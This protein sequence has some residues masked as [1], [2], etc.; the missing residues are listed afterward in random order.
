MLSEGRVVSK[1]IFH[2]FHFVVTFISTLNFAIVFKDTTVG[3]PA[4]RAV[5][6]TVCVADR[7]SVLET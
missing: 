6:T 3:Q 7:P 1:I 4:N 5:I 2:L